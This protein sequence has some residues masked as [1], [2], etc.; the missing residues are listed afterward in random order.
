MFQKSENIKWCSAK[1]ISSLS[2]SWSA[3]HLLYTH[4]STFLNPFSSRD[5][6]NVSKY[7]VFLQK[8]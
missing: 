1:K 3:Q 5:Y 4:K 2:S 8:K 7:R 6:G